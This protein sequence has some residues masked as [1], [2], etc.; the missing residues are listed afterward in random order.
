MPMFKLFTVIAAFTCIS[1]FSF[2]PEVYIVDSTD[3][4]ISQESKNECKIQVKKS[5]KTFEVHNNCR[6]LLKKL[7]KLQDNNEKA[8]I[9]SKVD[10]L[11]FALYGSNDF[12]DLSHI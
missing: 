6:R 8:I 2:Q 1:A 10:G 4:S 9:T 5:N 3:L 11:Q 12:K 7:V